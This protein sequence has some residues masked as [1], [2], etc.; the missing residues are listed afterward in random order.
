MGGPGQWGHGFARMTK[1]GPRWTG[2]VRLVPDAL[3]LPLRW[4]EPRR[5]FVNSMSDLFHESLPFEDVAK[6][7]ERMAWG[8]WLVCRKKGCRCDCAHE[9]PP[10][11]GSCKC[12]RDVARH[13]Y[14]VLTKRPKRM[15]EFFDW[16]VENGSAHC[17]TYDEF[18]A[19]GL[20]LGVS[21]EDQDTANERIPLLLSVP[22]HRA[23]VRWVSYEPALG[24]VDFTD[25]S[26]CDRLGGFIS[27]L[28]WIVVGGES[29][30]GARPFD[31]AWAR[32]TV[33]QCRAAS[34]PVFVKQ[35]GR[36]IVGDHVGF[37]VDRWLVD[38]GRRV[39]VPGVYKAKERPTD[40]VAF[41]L[42][43]K[44]GDPNYWPEDLRVREF[45]S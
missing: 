4:R 9:E 33:E 36:W 8:Q 5:I 31:V 38:G 20:C 30:S 29:G 16:L 41:T 25:P 7:F 12:Y 14:Q 19:D 32:S 11:P 6:V 1:A 27:F 28:D 21:I 3:D 43:G 22:S 15:L 24:P 18:G 39:F 10:E 13:T 45:P 35:M 40:A 23:A 17:P 42:G 37:R 44:G 34:V 2:R 26:V